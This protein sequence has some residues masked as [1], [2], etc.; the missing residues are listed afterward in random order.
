MSDPVIKREWIFLAALLAFIVS[1]FVLFYKL[2][3]P[4]FAPIA[5]AVII[6]VTCNPA[7]QWL[8]AR[9]KPRGL[10][11]F[12]ST[13][14]VAILILGPSVWLIMTLV[15]EARNLYDWIQTGE[16]TSQVINELA[17][18]I[19]PIIQELGQKLGGFIDMS[20]WDFQSVAISFV[21]KL[22]KWIVDNTTATLTNVGKVALQFL[23]MLLTMYYLFKDGAPL[24]ENVKSAIPLPGKRA[25]EMLSHVT[26]VV[27]ATIYGGLV[28]AAIQ[29]TLGGLLFWILGL[30][31]PVLWGAVMGFFAL[32]PVLGAFVVYIP[33][34]LVLIAGGSYIK[35]IILL[36]VG[37]G[38]VSQIDNVLRPLL[39]SGKTQMHPLLLFFS[40]AGGV[41]VFGLLGLVLGP[42]IAA[43][44]IALLEVYR[45]ALR[46]PEIP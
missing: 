36:A 6:V 41:S 12:I 44:F 14:A 18:R 33:A 42:V 40:I 5:W 21:G 1:V 9:V 35:A 15:G 4:F 28:V 32:I 27:R 26:D 37:I 43:L 13:T 30:P 7:H 23:M 31:S 20:K 8:A 19:D 39:I 10:A 3:V 29:G 38:L 16:W 25:G 45:I 22:S 11:A 2:I 34:A 24:F 17:A 46:A